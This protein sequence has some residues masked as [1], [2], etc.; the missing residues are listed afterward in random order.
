MLEQYPQI[1]D[2]LNTITADFETILGDNLLGVYLTGSLTTN[3]YIEKLSDIDLIVVLNNPVSSS[4]KEG[5]DAWSK[6]LQAKYPL[7]EFLDVAF[8]DRASIL[9]TDGNTQSIGLEFWKGK[10]SESDNTLGDNLL[11]WASI[12]Q[13]GIKLYGVE[14][15]EIIKDIPHKYL[16]N[17]MLKELKRLKE[18]MNEAFDDDIKFRYYAITTL[19][20][21]HYTNQMKGF[22]SKKE[23]LEWYK[24]QSG[25]HQLL[26]EAAMQF[27]AGNEQA[28]IRTRKE[29]YS[30]FIEEIENLI[31]T[32]NN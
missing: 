6:D 14:A 23:A 13:S 17:V 18:L 11:V 8:I 1:K 26:I 29:E 22:I 20:R 21:M 5:L 19:C 4:E 10:I 12:L 9:K 3:S 16:K 27:L 24:S 30:V 25:N 2:F 32:P 15:H 31:Q 28:L 7:S